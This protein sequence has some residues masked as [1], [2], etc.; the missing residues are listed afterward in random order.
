MVVGEFG[1][2]GQ[3]APKFAELA[4]NQK[5]EIVTCQLDSKKATTV[6]ERKWKQ[7]IAMKAH[8]LVGKMNV[9]SVAYKM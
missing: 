7:K 5:L 3:V 6:K 9:A 2:R 1:L 8:V 4:N